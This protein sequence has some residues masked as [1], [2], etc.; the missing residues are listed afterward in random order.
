[1]INN[2]MLYTG[3]S[4]SSST[5]RHTLTITYSI[6]G[7]T[8][9]ATYT[10]TYAEGTSYGVPSPT[11]VGYT[12]SQARVDGVMGEEDISVTVTYSVN[13]YQLRVVYMDVGGTV[14]HDP[15]V[16]S[17][18]YK[19]SYSVTSPTISGYTVTEG[20]ETISGTMPARDVIENVFYT[21]DIEDD[22]ETP[23]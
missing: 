11:I 17:V 13:A 4:G 7:E 20:Q 10:A 1:M 23:A 8:A 9:P 16:Q 2:P 22:A 15:S 19:A 21:P 5:T 14:L 12:P 3:S 18:Y 6:S